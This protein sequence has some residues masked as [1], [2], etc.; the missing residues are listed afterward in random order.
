MHHLKELEGVNA[1]SIKFW[2]RWSFDLSSR[3]INICQLK[4]RQWFNWILGNLICG[5]R[6]PILAAEHTHS[7]QVFSP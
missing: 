1:D 6:V 7:V 3:Q 4:M 2:A 5:G